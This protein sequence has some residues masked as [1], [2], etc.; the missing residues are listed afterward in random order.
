MH[1]GDRCGDCSS[2]NL[3]CMSLVVVMILLSLHGPGLLLSPNFS[4]I[5]VAKTLNTNGWTNGVSET[6]VFKRPDD[7]NSIKSFD[8]TI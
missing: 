8:S 6:D 2:C 7:I 4:V 1:A 3:F 5:A